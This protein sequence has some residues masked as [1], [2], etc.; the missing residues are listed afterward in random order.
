MVGID[1][2][3]DGE[4]R[5]VRD[6]FKGD[7][8]DQVIQQIWAAADKLGGVE[9]KY[10]KVLLLTGKRKTA[11]AEMKWENITTAWF[12]DAPSEG[13][14]NK[15]LTKVPLSSLVQSILD[16]RQDS[17]FVFP[18]KRD[19][20]IDAGEKLTKAIIKAGA[21]EDFILHGCRHIAE[22]KLAELHIPAHIRD[23]LFDHVEDRGSGKTYDHHEY[24]GQM[25]EA[26]ERWARFIA[27]V[28]DAQL[29]AAHKKF[30]A[31]GD[32]ACIKVFNEAIAAGGA[33]WER[34]L[35]TIVSGPP[36]NVVALPKRG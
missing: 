18:G 11:L 25:R 16:P 35:Q 30:V 2:P 20:R 22:T 19:G 7:T 34:Y 1:K 15:R 3:Y 10:L 17:G 6:W 8:A 9:G 14:K 4:F 26:L 13:R 12:W 36:L 33:S 27:L 29:Y 32:Q 5:R 21:N 24:E 28:I 31:D 23:R